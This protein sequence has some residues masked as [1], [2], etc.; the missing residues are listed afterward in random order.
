MQMG[1]FINLT[2]YPTIY[3]L[4]EADSSGRL[5]GRMLQ[6]RATRLTQAPVTDPGSL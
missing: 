2:G 5:D 1:R 3:A 6:R 4:F